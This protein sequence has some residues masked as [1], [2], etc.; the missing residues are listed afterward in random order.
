MKAIKFTHPMK[1][2]GSY[3]GWWAGYKF[4]E[5]LEYKANGRH[6][7]VDYN[8]GSGHEDKGF[9]V[10]A[11]ANGKV[12]HVGRH[13]TKGF[14]RTIIIKHDLDP[15]LQNQ[16]G[17]R[18]MYSRYM[19]LG[20]F[21]PGLAVGDQVKVGQKIGL[22]GDDGTVWSHLHIDLWK[23]TPSGLGVHL[24]YHDTT[25]L[26]S[27]LD[28]YRV[29]ERHKNEVEETMYKNKPATYWG[30]LYEKMKARAD[31]LTATVASRDK[32]VTELLGVIESLRLEIVAYIGSDQEDS[33]K[34]EALLRDLAVA[35]EQLKDLQEVVKRP[36][37]LRE[38]FDVITAYIKS[39]FKGEQK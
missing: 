13:L 6:T 3:N 17:C 29:I 34:I 22:V 25:Q 7:G 37:S 18:W 36:V 39:K 1:F 12:V 4:K 27:Y 21:T 2:T 38:A 32:R 30:P 15:R 20:A 28:P 16:Y 11:I 33:E 35:N 24:D 19:H 8:W 10:H 31:Q 26:L 23:D 14:G 9:T 5:Q